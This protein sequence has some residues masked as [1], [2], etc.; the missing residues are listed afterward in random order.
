MS[1]PARSSSGRGR[2][3][4]A[5]RRGGGRCVRHDDLLYRLPADA[6]PAVLPRR[7]QYVSLARKG[8]GLCTAFTTGTWVCVQVVARPFPPGPM[9][10]PC[11]FWEHPPAA[12]PSV[13]P[14]GP[15]GPCAPAVTV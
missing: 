2:S 1:T 5:D 12:C 11:V 14:L 15:G 3:S 10:E 8:Y 13:E 9:A 4:C 6:R 7:R